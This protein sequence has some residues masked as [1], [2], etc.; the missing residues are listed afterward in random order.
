MTLSIGKYCAGAVFGVRGIGA[1]VTVVPRRA[2]VTD[3]FGRERVLGERRRRTATLIPDW[4]CFPTLS[5][6]HPTVV[7]RAVAR[8]WSSMKSVGGARS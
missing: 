1:V 5:T 6:L 4:L 8:C 2:V 3:L 7:A